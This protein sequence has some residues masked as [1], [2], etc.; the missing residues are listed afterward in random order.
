[1][2]ALVGGSIRDGFNAL[3]STYFNVSNLGYTALFLMGAFFFV[4]GIIFL[5]GINEPQRKG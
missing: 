4:L 5:R 1:L 3:G 2:A